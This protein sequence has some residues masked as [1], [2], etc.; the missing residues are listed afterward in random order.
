M[1]DLRRGVSRL[2]SNYG[3]LGLTLAFGLL[4]VPLLIYWIGVEAFGV[5]SLLGPTMGLAQVGGKVIDQT[6]IHEL[7]SV[8]HA[9]PRARFLRT[10]QSAWFVSGVGAAAVA[11]IAALLVFALL[12]NLQIG[13]ELLGSAQVM[14]A[15]L[16]CFTVGR[17]ILSPAMAMYL[18]RERFITRNLLIVATRSSG[19]VAAT[20]GVLVIERGRSAEGLLFYGILAPSL[21]LFWAVLPAVWVMLKER[22]LV[23]R[24]RRGDIRAIAKT[25]SWNTL[26][27]V[28]ISLTGRVPLIFVNALFGNTGSAIYGLAWRLSSYARMIIVGATYGLEAVSTRISATDSTGDAVRRFVVHATRLNAT[29]ALP[30][31]VG[32]LILTEPVLV[33]WVGMRVP[34]AASLAKDAVLISQIVVVGLTLRGIGDG[35]IQILYGSGKVARYAP[36]L[37][38]L[39]LATPV[40]AYLAART[41]APPHD[42]DSIAWVTSGAYVLG[43]LVGLPILA[44]RLIVAP[45]RSFFTPMIRPAIASLVLLP[46]LLGFDRLVTQWTLLH[47]AGAILAS[48]AAYA[49]SVWALVLTSQE[50]AMFKRRIPVAL[51]LAPRRAP[52]DAPPE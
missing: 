31:A 2:A 27:T 52:R 11:I 36:Y 17:M 49:L 39:A 4:E 40:A 18:V 19:L 43:Y 10:Y 6:F 7:G 42:F 29:I 46:I 1:G 13:P 22:D 34:E 21:M 15:M 50:R 26:A 5:V 25:F 28:S 45:I 24:P 14:G 30:A 38:A 44:A 51:G 23:P 41:F 8:Y 37:A 33:L 47:L 48:G 20:V 3:R 35:W 9:Q 32:I 16:A 12:P